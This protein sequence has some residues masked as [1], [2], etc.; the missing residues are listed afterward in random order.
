MLFVRLFLRTER[1][2]STFSLRTEIS[3]ALNFYLQ[4]LREVVEEA[5]MIV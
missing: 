5:A 3:D 2:S 1:F 4:G